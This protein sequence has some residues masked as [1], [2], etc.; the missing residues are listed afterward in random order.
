MESKIDI[1]AF[2]NRL[3]DNMKIGSPR[4]Q[5]P[6]GFLSIFIHNPKCFYGRFDNSSFELTTN[7]D[8]FPIL[9][10]LK[11]TYKNTGNKL[12]VNYSVEPV[13]K[14]RIAWVKYFPIFAFII[15][16]SVFYFEAKPPIEVYI[17]FNIFIVFSFFFSRLMMKWQNKRL[18]RKF[19][20]I[21]EIIN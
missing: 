2:R 18:E 12:L 10:F 16:N 15:S 7:S 21:F 1:T 20:K 5:I 8:F 17:A 4:L 19:N 11:G 14:L 13:G 3:K 6:L 9:Y